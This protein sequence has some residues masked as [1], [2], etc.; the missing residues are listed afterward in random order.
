M[1]LVFFIDGK[2]FVDGLCLNYIA[3]VFLGSL[4]VVFVARMNEVAS[5]L[6]NYKFFVLFILINLFKKNKDNGKNNNNN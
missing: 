6:A 4:G 1:S 3:F 2:S 5:E